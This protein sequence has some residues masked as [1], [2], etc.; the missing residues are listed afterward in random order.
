MVKP[1]RDAMNRVVYDDDRQITYSEIIQVSI[2]AASTIRRA[3]EPTVE[4]IGRQLA[5]A[6]QLMQT[7]A[8]TTAGMVAWAGLEAAMRRALHER[9]GSTP[10]VLLRSLYAAG[11]IS[12]EELSVLDGA[13]KLR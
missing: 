11:N 2:D 4:Q 5:E 12:R 7:G 1:I 6:E 13:Y 9:N 8:L 10:N 3:A